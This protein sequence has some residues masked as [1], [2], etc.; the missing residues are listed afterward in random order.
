[1]SFEPGSCPSYH[2]PVP[3]AAT[4]AVRIL[5]RMRRVAKLIVLLIGAITLIASVRIAHADDRTEFELA[6]NPFNAGHYAEAVERFRALLDPSSSTR[7]TDPWLVER[8]R[9]YLV[10]SLI[11]TDRVKE[12]DAEIETILRQNP[13]AVPDPVFPTQVF[14]RFTEVRER[15]RVELDQKAREKAKADQERLRIE[16]E[17]AR[18]EKDRVKELERLAMQETRVEVHSRWIA[19]IPFGVGQFQNDQI[20]LG[21]TFLGAEAAL[22]STAIASSVIVQSLESQGTRPNVDLADLKLRIHGW[23]QVNRLS[24]V[25]LAVVAAG[26]VTHAQLTFTPETTQVRHRP[27]PPS[28]QVAPSAAAIDGGAVVGVQGCF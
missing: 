17:K 2:G 3:S 6:K 23:T 5:A 16:Q 8:A 11:A 19:L 28:L 24:F 15:I 14:D 13:T 20:A 10:A 26:G 9:M 27:L 1:M 7:I 12:A 18:R 22:A 21:W 25:A 4:H